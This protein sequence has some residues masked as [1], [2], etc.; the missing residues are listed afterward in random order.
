MNNHTT[1][2]YARAGWKPKADIYRIENGLLIKLELAGVLEND[3]K[4]TLNENVIIIE[5]YRRDWCV[6]D[7]KDLLSMEITY[8][9]FKR[10]ISLPISVN[11]SKMQTEFR[12][13]MLLIYLIQ[14]D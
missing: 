5:G 8:D 7:I 2:I 6:T 9:Y 11:T 1:H 12:N 13:G 14:T 4:I 3:Y 10:S